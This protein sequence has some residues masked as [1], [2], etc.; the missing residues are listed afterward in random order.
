MVQ[1]KRTQSQ[2]WE[3]LWQAEIEETLI[4]SGGKVGHVLENGEKAEEMRVR[5]QS[6]NVLYWRQQEPQ[7]I[8]KTRKT[9]LVFKDESY[10]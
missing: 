10:E 2:A 1:T 4:Q 9:W 8:G 6:W 5:D 3:W 7:K